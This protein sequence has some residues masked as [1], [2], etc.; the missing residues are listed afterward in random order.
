MHPFLARFS[1]PVGSAHTPS[2]VDFITIMPVFKLSVHT[3]RCK[4]FASSQGA[5]IQ[6]SCSSPVV[7]IT[8]IAFG[9][10]GSTT[11]FGAVMRSRADVYPSPTPDQF[12]RETPQPSAEQQRGVKPP[13]F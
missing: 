11:A 9:W 12:Q 5:R 13:S 7:K 4:A 3:G 2:W 6:T 8:G 10:I 1:E